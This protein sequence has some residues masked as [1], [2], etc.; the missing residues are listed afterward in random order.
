MT[1][2]TTFLRWYV[3]A[4]CGCKALR[5]PKAPVRDLRYKGPMID[6]VFKTEYDAKV[7]QGCS[8]G[9]TSTRVDSKGSL[10]TLTKFMEI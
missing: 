1:E 6:G 5:M 8:T 4:Q 3:T 2:S 9:L 10:T 7:L